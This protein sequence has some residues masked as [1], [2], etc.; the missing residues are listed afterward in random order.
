MTPEQQVTV[1]RI[2]AAAVQAEQST[3]CPAEITTAQCILESG[4]LQHAPGNNC[5]GIKAY[6]G[7][8]GTQLID[9][10]EWF[11]DAEAAKFLERGQGRAAV[12]I[13]PVADQRRGQ[14]ALRLPRSVRD[15]REPGRL[16]RLSRRAAATR[17]VQTG[18]GAVP[19]RSRPLR[20]RARRGAALCDRSRVCVAGASD[21]GRAV[22]DGDAQREPGEGDTEC[23]SFRRSTFSA[24]GWPWRPRGMA[25]R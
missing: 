6:A 5:F 8:F 2:A 3:G 9:T 24:C 7:C 1:A 11:T 21:R 20:V 10:H 25:G 17:R 22:R 15:V 13:Q 19:E 18:V 4:Y 23:L 16:L 12:A 14:E